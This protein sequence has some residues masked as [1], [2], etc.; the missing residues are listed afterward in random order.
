[1]KG[2]F[3]SGLVPAGVSALS[4]RIE[5]WRG[6]RA[7]RSEPMPGELWEQAAGL[8]KIHGVYQISQALHLGY[9][10]LKKRAAGNV[11]SPKSKWRAKAEFVEVVGLC[12]ESAGRIELEIESSG[13]S[14]LR[15]RDVSGRVDIAE[16][17]E[18]FC[19]SLG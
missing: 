14:R 10:A 15:L 12:G 13:G 4:R 9:G 11:S 2:R 18:S 19:R 5:G 16:V 6:S 8:A 7:N 1:M 3:A 17:I